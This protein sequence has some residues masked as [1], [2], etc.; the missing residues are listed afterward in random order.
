MQFVVTKKFGKRA[1]FLT[2]ESMAHR[3]Q[4]L[5]SFLLASINMCAPGGAMARGAIDCCDVQFNPLSLVIPGVPPIMP[6]KASD[7]PFNKVVSSGIDIV[8]QTIKNGGD[9]TQ[10]IL[11]AALPPSMTKI[12][13]IH[14]AVTVISEGAGGVTQV[15]V[16]GRGSDTVKIYQSANEQLTKQVTQ[17]LGADTAH[18]LMAWQSLKDEKEKFD[19]DVNATAAAVRFA[20]RQMSSVISKDATAL[21]EARRGKIVQ[22]IVDVSLSIPRSADENFYKATHESALIKQASQSAAAVYGGPGGAAAYAAW[23]AYRTTGN[24]NVAW[25]EGIRT[26]ITS[27][28]GAEASSIPNGTIGQTL[29]KAAVAGTAGGIAVAMQGG[30]EDAIKYAF[31]RGGG[32]V[33]VQG[34]TN[35]LKAYSSQAAD[36]VNTVQCI[37]ARDLDC[38]SHTK[39]ATEIKDGAAKYVLGANGKPKLL[40]VSE[41]TSKWTNFDPNSPEGQVNA[42]ITS[43]SKLPASSIVPVDG[44]TLPSNFVS[45]NRGHGLACLVRAASQC[46]SNC[47]GLT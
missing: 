18:Y 37:S 47:I 7:D 28:L 6:G 14:D 36:A 11:D 40:S 19:Q 33:L 39:W 8:R 23:Y 24:I 1:H 46:F 12:P 35:Q 9:P 20:G 25:R 15:I 13:L 26:A 27:E 43:I 31:L 30:D 41:Y 3:R 32:Y 34:A 29:T 10:A 22:S 42:F 17:V 44:M 45:H 21:D 16:K 4:L 5:L 38:V 2:R